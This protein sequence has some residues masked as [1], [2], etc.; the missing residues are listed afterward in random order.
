MHQDLKFDPAL[1]K[2]LF[3]QLR[4]AV[5]SQDAAATYLEVSRQRVAQLESA[6]EDN[7]KEV[8]TWEQV[9][10]LEQA[11]G[12]SIVFAALADLSDGKPATDIMDASIAAVAASSAALQA[13]AEMMADHK[14][15]AHEIPGA[16]DAAR[17]N[18]DAADR[19]VQS[20]ERQAAI[21]H[22]AGRA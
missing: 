19:H 12:R 11:I 9:F 2:A 16:L 10:T 1:L 20:I 13:S 17:R 21:L 7:A 4:K 22:T 15:E 3:C 6:H 18:R 14:V 8:P 5:G